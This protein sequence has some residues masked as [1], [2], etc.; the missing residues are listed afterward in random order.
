MWIQVYSC[1]VFVPVNLCSGR[2]WFPH[3]GVEETETL[4]KYLIW[5]NKNK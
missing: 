2:K 4:Q 5:M 1:A 3:I